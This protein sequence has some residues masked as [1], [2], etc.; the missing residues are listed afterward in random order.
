MQ[1]PVEHLVAGEHLGP[2]ADALVGRDQDA[3]A[4]VAIAHQPEQQGGL[5]CR[6]IGSKPTSS[7]TS[8]ATLMYLRRRNRA[9]LTCGVPLHRGQELLEPEETDGE[10]VLDGSDR[11]RHRQ[12]RLAD[13]G[14]PLQQEVVALADPRTGSERVDLTAVD[15]RAETRS[16]RLPTSARSAGPRGATRCGCAAPRA[17]PAPDPRARRASGAGSCGASPCQSTGSSSSSAACW[18]PS[19]DQPI[20]RGVEIDLRG[21]R[22]LGRG[23]RAHRA[24]SA[25][26][27]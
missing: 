1:Q 20:A 17:T 7:I 27:A 2:V 10:A 21:Q 3:A 25:R 19:R 15:W 22:C 4:A 13:A 8:R 12:V 16:Q 26:A 14:W 11:E 23:R 6:V 5:A 18:R 24:N 9:G